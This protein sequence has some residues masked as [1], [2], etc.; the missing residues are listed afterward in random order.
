[1]QLVDYRI[2]DRR[3]HIGDRSVTRH[4]TAE[5][6]LCARNYLRPF[7]GDGDRD[8]S[9]QGLDLQEPSREV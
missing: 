1:M 6:G 5:P 8:D 4:V 3:R 9:D 2:V 7:V